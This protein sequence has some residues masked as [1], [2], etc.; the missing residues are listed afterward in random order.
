MIR[1]T[2]YSDQTIAIMGLGRSGLSAARALMDVGSEVWAW[3]DS[4]AHRNA[5]KE[6][7][8]PLVDLSACDWSVP[9]ALVL[10]PGIPD[11]LPA[12]HPVATAAR[13]AGC[14]IIC[15][16][17]LL[18]QTIDEAT[19]VGVTGTN[20]KSTTCAL[21]GHILKTAARS[22]Q[23]GGNFGVPALDLDPLDAEGTY[24][25]ELSS[26]QLE[27]V[28]S[29]S[30]DV[31]VFLNISA[32]H[33]DRHGDL[34]GYVDAKRAI[35]SAPPAN[36][37]AVVG[38]DDRHSRAIC[39]ELML[40]GAVRLVPVSTMSRVPGGVYVNDGILFDDLANQHEPIADLKTL[41]NLP[42]QHN[43]QN[44][45]A[46]YAVARILGLNAAEIIGGVLSF[47][48]LVHRQEMLKERAG[49]T[50]VNDSKAT[51]TEAAAR[52]IA[53][54]ASIYWIAGGRSKEAG[55]G[56]IEPYLDHVRH[57]YL[58][59]E[60]ADGL[61]AALADRV[62]VSKC[63]TLDRAFEAAFEDAKQVASS[64]RPVVLLSPACASFDQFD[65][66]EAR[67]NAFKAL[68]EAVQ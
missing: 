11:R 17:E 56:A 49:V 61:A 16:V 62:G 57:A 48:G 14:K 9:A 38:M 15:D 7:G 46:A 2:S 39:M 43:W 40:E 27:R 59:G 55:L 26:Y 34:D 22:V 20:G 4:E 42:G 33:L 31:S 30:L 50:F 54:Y 25:L 47:P 41:E 29:L 58:I 1:P 68:V 13:A 53:C 19:Y 8:I 6:E 28:P 10:S 21:L 24:V 36:A 51:N 37:T 45:A 32:D 12:P 60:A 64:E 52:A 23:I 63:G 66:F 18:L 44:T 35:F 3:D 65:S 67:G 5:A